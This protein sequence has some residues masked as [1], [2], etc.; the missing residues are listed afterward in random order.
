[1][2]D[3]KEKKNADKGKMDAG[4]I[5]LAAV[6]I[7]AVLAAVGY[8]GGFFSPASPPSNGTVAQPLAAPEA[9][10][11]LA[12]FDKGAALDSYTIN[13]TETD[14]GVKSSYFIVKNGSD[15]F[16]SVQ[17]MFGRM[18][19]YFGK[20]NQT[21]VSCLAYGGS[22]KCAV[23]GNN[24][25]MA[26]IGA[27]LKILRPNPTAYLSQGEDTRKHIAT[28]AIKITPG[29]QSEK[30]GPFDTQKIS[31]TL[32]Y[33]NLTVQ[34]MVSLGLS[35]TDQSRLALTDQKVSFWIDT[36]T[37][38]IVKSHASYNNQGVAVA[39][40]REYSELSTLP[41]AVPPKP[42]SVVVPAAFV[43]FYKQSTADYS[44]RAACFAQ[45]GASKDACLKSIA[46]NSGDWETC[47]LI[48]STSEYESC[49]LI[50]AQETNNYVI[51]ANL[52]K[53]AD[54]CYIAVAS[55]TGNFDLCKL[56]KNASLSTACI[57]AATAGKKK[58]EANAA[59]MEAAYTG[60]NCAEDAGCK[61]AGNAHQYCVPANSTT[62]F[63]NDTSPLYSCLAG[64]PCGCNGGY[65]G[66]AKN[67]TYYACVTA[68]EDE[69]LKEY[70]GSLIPDNSTIVNVTRK[71]VPG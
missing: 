9:K 35:P 43:E 55:E 61:A 27:S 3:A 56:V 51:C 49:S 5:A 4:A 36:A 22:E 17:G 52:T 6:V 67:E 14:S 18:Y 24:S 28:G 23:A 58:A 40:D 26:D 45:T 54:D 41:G 16:V 64:A 7:I 15:S 70:I 66:F 30:I 11:L 44:S 42:M 46:A 21:D 71:A 65:C 62:V 53:I 57:D 63:A 29:M 13:Y 59:Q 47:K 2:A 33:S 1:M 31:Y 32:D 39:Y 25:D 48:N 68:I 38:L 12:S 34:Q 8:Y 19:G 37:G 69:A 60:R 50:V 10:L 20:D